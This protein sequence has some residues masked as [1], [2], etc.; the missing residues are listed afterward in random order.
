MKQFVLS[1]RTRLTHDGQVNI[2]AATTQWRM[3]AESMYTGQ[4]GE[5]LRTTKW[6]AT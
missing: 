6:V 1:T 3:A 5:T 4:R 2:R